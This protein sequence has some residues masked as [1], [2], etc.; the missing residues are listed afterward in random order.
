M[1]RLGL[2]PRDV[3]ILGVILL[4]GV[5]ALDAQPAAAAGLVIEPAN[6]TIT[7]PNEVFAVTGTT[8]PAE[9]A[10]IVNPLSGQP[11]SGLAGAVG[12]A[13]STDFQIVANNCPTTL[14][15]GSNCQIAVTFTPTALGTRSEIGRAH[16]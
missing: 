3:T 12:G 4:I 6:L 13:N 7:F 8:S 15:P 1:L 14:N 5:L 16:V 9:N 11:V 10:S 2:F